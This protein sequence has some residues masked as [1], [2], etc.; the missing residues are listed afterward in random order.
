MKLY[1]IVNMYYS[2]SSVGAQCQH[3][4]S[5]LFIKYD[6]SSREWAEVH[7]WAR[8][9]KT[10]V[11]IR[12]GGHP[13]MLVL[14]QELIGMKVPFSVFRESSNNDSLSV[15]SFVMDTQHVTLMEQVRKEKL[16][17]LDVLRIAEQNGFRLKCTPQ[18]LLYVAYSRLVS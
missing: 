13:D 2:G 11:N 7:E 8:S 12:G 14:E 3:G 18:F 9:H 4:I 15:I 1:T 6:P 17:E 10:V 5:E 16:N